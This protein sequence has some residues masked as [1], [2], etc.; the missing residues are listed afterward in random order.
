MIRRLLP[1]VLLGACAAP[2]E[3]LPPGPPDPD[4]D[5]T[6]VRSLIWAGRSDEA[7]SLL[8]QCGWAATGSVAAERM[9]QD[10]L[11]A[12]GERAQLAAE[13]EEILAERGPDPDLLYLR[14]RLISDPERRLLELESAARRHPAHA[15]LALGTAATLQEFRRWDEAEEWLSASAAAD[16]PASAAF[17]RLLMA[18]QQ[19]ESGRMYSAWRILERDAFIL[20]SRE[21]LAECIRLASMLG[22]DRRMARAS[23]EYALRAAPAANDAAAAMDRVI[24]RLVAE[25]PWMRGAS[26]DETLRRVDAWA[27]L[28]GAPVGWSEQRRYAIAGLAELVQPEAF[29]GGVAA[30]WMERGRFLLIGRAPGRGVDWLYL[31]DARRILLPVADAPSVE[32]IVARRGLEPSDRTIPGG[33]PFYGFFVRLDLVEAGARS[34]TREVERFRGGDFSISGIAR[35]RAADGPLESWDLALRLRARR[36]AA[37]GATVHDLELAQL[38]VH[39]TSHLPETLPWARDGVPILALAPAVL[40][41]LSKFDDPILFLEERAQLRALASGVETD[42]IFAEVLDRANAPRDPYF[43]PY[44]ALLEDLVDLGRK[45]GLPPLHA[46]DGLPPGTIAR[47]ARKIQKGRGLEGTPRSLLA[48]ALRGLDA[49]KSFEQFPAQDAAARLLHDGEVEP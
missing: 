3:P 11:L 37:G 34:R 25:E 44:R 2:L 32:L 33:A 21:A 16:D 39:E 19:A 5:L 1:L 17:R 30:A 45:E 28:A 7:L 14:A 38:L 47:L 4:L 23:A 22:S 40:R 43:K 26:L 10:L 27:L 36:L 48:A 12:R 41:S 24:E 49:G 6:E 20:G 31:Q 15:W 13:T 9:R 46:W 42:W 8:D 35:P 29:R 18:R